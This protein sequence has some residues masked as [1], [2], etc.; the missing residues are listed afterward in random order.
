[1][2]TVRSVQAFGLT[3]NRLAEQRQSM[4]VPETSLHQ[5]AFVMDGLVYH[6]DGDTA[7][8]NAGGINAINLTVAHF[9]AD[10]TTACKQMAGWHARVSAPDSPW[11]IIEFFG[12]KIFSRVSVFRLV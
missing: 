3:A 2:P 10:F 9:E 8:L 1:M 11:M 6:S 4:T 7:A 12:S 5:A